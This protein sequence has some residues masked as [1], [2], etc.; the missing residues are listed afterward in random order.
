L[1]DLITF[2]IETSVRAS[3]KSTCRKQNVIICGDFN[4]LKR[5]VGDFMTTFGLR[6]LVNF[7]TRGLT[8]L[9]LVLTNI[10]SYE[11]AERLPPVGRSDH[12]AIICK[13][14]KPKSLKVS[15]KVEFRPITHS[16]KIKFNAKMV[17]TDWSKL[18]SSVGTPD[19]QAETLLAT[20]QSVFTWAFPPK[21]VRMRVGNKPWMKPSLTALINARDRAYSAAKHGKYV[22]LK[23]KVIQHIHQLKKDY[24]IKSQLRIMADRQSEGDDGQIRQGPLPWKAVKNLLQGTMSSSPILCPD[25]INE[26]FKKSFQ[27]DLQSCEDVQLDYENWEPEKFQFTVFEVEKELSRTKNSSPGI[28]GIPAWVLRQ[29]SVILAEAL[30]QVFNSS[31]AMGLYPEV[32]KRALICPIPKVSNPSATDFRPISLLPVISKVFERLVMRKWFVP[33]AASKMDPLQFAF[34]PG[35]GKGCT[36]ALALMQHKILKYLDEASGAVRL[37]LVDLS[38]AFDCATR[39][40]TVRALIRLGIAPQLV[41]WTYSYMGLRTQA[42]KGVNGLSKWIAVTSGVPQ[43][44]VLGPFL[45][46]AIID[47]LKPC[48]DNSIMFKYADDITVLHFIRKQEEDQLNEEWT[49]IKDWCMSAQLFPNASKT[50]VLN[51]VTAKKLGECLPVKDGETVLETVKTAKLLGLTISDDLKWVAHV[52]ASIQRA[53]KRLFSLIQ[54]RNNGMPP[55]LLWDYYCTAIRSVLIYAYPAWCNCGEGLWN[56]L[57]K[58]ERRAEKIIGVAVGGTSAKEAADSVASNLV[59]KVFM[60][61][62]HPLAEIV[63]QRDME[64][65]KHNRQSK[66]FVSCWAKTTRFKESLTSYADST[67]DPVS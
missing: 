48:H 53:S 64:I 44:S 32:F 10:P 62:S 65:L 15:K 60:C 6:N 30:T 37:L 63:V 14:T 42:V 12:T 46:A 40:V 27:E 28:D 9:D 31:L 18:V 13:P 43:G 11:G 5:N 49:N 55:A 57:T 7:H 29:Y 4:D 2:H 61:P 8:T 19:E 36:T 59:K 3:E 16:R 47:N 34:V 45:F 52:E 20:V 51:I 24:L 17:E 33:Q 54:L 25:E 67:S 41:Y 1:E 21:V 35:V 39:S 58:V 66:K 26:M 38:K 56:R 50:K 23:E 22:Q